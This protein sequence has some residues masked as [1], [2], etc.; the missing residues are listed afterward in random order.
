MPT[1]HYLWNPIHGQIDR[2]MD[3]NGN[4][5]VEYTREPDGTL[6]SEHRNGVDRFYHYDGAG[7]TTALTDINGDVTDTFAY[8]AF[9]EETARTGTTPT[10]FR[11]HGAQGYYWD[12]EIA[13]YMVGRRPFSAV[14]GRWLAVDPLEFI[15]GPNRY[16]YALN[17]PLVRVDP[18]G[19]LSW[20]EVEGPS[21]KDGKKAASHTVENCGKYA[22]HI[23]WNLDETKKKFPDGYII[24]QVTIRQKL[25]DCCGKGIDMVGSCNPRRLGAIDKNLWQDVYYE[26]WRVKGGKVFFDADQVAPKKPADPIHD[27]FMWGGKDESKGCHT[28]YGEA[29]FVTKLAGIE[30]LKPGK[31]VEAGNLFSVCE[32]RK[33]VQWRELVKDHKGKVAHR[34]QAVQWKCCTGD[35]PT[36]TEKHG[37]TAKM[38]NLCD[39]PD[40]P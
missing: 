18:S 24:Q 1:V 12:E 9:G 5:L 31:I 20:N 2:E 23:A 14:H 25:L 37:E 29:I 32:L 15:E 21:D 22:W 34:V 19:M 30:F 16:D 17:N 39:K 35:D 36:P 26:I 33:G 7:N 28:K 11:Y 10:P 40:A 27:T 4:V 3:E 6:I 13:E 38:D 8:N